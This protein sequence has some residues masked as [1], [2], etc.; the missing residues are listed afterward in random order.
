MKIL[1]IT[2]ITIFLFLL[3]LAIGSYFYLDKK[4][5]PPPNYLSLSKTNDSIPITWLTNEANQ[6]AALLL[7]IQIK[8]VRKQF[9]MQF[10]LGSHSTLF[11]SMAIESINKRNGE[12]I[13]I[14]STNILKTFAFNLGEI[15]VSADQ[16]RVIDYGE[17]INWQ[18]TT[19]L[20]IIGT[21]GADLIEHKPIVL[22]FKNSYCIL[23]KT[24]ADFDPNLDLL[25]FKFEKRR[26]LLPAIINGEPTELLFDSGTSGFE[27]I[28]DKKTWQQMAKPNTTEINYDV[29]SWGRTLTVHDIG[30]DNVIFFGKT[31]IGLNRVSYIESTSFIQ[32][33]LM[34]LSGMGGMI[35][36]EL[37]KEK[38]LILDCTNEKFVV[39][40]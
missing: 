21:I 17:E 1:K 12:L 15:M 27:F 22:D 9:Y 26:V 11:Y 28:T 32:N 16:F 10:D 40:D 8:G 36:N 4:F 5:T 18:D 29:N 33:L 19:S 38:V 37:F 20:N 6:R 39:V 2:T 23:G 14:D 3:F 13:P 30:S 25:D 34:R 35:G 7:P 31:G 24:A